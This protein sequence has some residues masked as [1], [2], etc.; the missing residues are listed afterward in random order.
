LESTGVRTN[1]GPRPKRASAYAHDG[2]EFVASWD[3]AELGL[4]PGNMHTP[5]K[6]FATDVAKVLTE[7]SPSVIASVVIMPV[8]D[9]SEEGPGVEDA[10][11]REVRE[12]DPELVDYLSGNQRFIPTGPPFQSGTDVESP[13]GQ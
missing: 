4:F 12:S 10:L 13:N 7:M 8:P 5:A 11:L 1:T 9:P 2:T 6:L 3:E